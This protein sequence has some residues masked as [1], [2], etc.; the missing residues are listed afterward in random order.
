MKRT[1]IAALVVALLVA[2][3]A[4]VAVAK[5]FVCD[6]PGDNDP[7]LLSCTGTPKDDL[8][9]GTTKGETIR[10]LDGDDTINGYGGHEVNLVGEAGC[11][12]INGGAGEDR[13]DA[14]RKDDCTNPLVDGAGE[15]VRAGPGNDRVF[16]DDDKPDIIDCG[17]GID[18]ADTDPFG[19]GGIY[20]VS[21]NC[22]NRS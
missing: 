19:P 9:T 14:Q 10:A 21:S 13:L 17:G 12:K 4:G 11:D 5:T 8:I 2:L 16:A 18:T 1:T 22:E 7:A 6:G 3:F 20:E 15:F